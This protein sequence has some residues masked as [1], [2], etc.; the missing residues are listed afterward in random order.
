MSTGQPDSPRLIADVGGTNA[1]FALVHADSDT[2]TDE[3]TLRGADYPDFGAAVE[4]YL[5]RVGGPR[6]TLGF[7]AIANPVTGDR[8]RMTNHAWA[9]SIEETRRRL[10]FEH[11]RFINDFAA[12]ALAIPHLPDR[13]KAKMGGGEPMARRPIGVLGPGTGLGVSG[14]IPTP[15]GEWVPIE[16]EGGHVT[17]S[18]VTRREM[19]IADALRKRHGHCSAERLVSGVGLK[20]TYAAICALDGVTARDI[21]P[22]G[23]SAGAASGNDPQCAETINVFTMAL[24]TT[25]ANLAV[26]LGALG[27]IFLCGGILPRLGSQFDEMAFRE[28][29]E[30]KGRFHDY[31]MAVPTYVVHARSP[32]LLG[33]AK[34]LGPS[35]G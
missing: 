22:D 29:F 24:A 8:L 3:V 1:R 19:D 5:E 14:L 31:L 15:A 27:G 12:Q 16:G 34:T 32:A 6:P 4:A 18:P 26:T 25:A 2:P 10:G 9:F 28:R 7:C 17:Y 30:D 20:A 11:L 21:E 23:I 13:D 35:T 33:L